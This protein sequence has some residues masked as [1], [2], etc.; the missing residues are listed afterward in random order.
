[1]VSPLH[2]LVPISLSLGGYHVAHILGQKNYLDESRRTESRKWT[3]TWGIFATSISKTWK[4]GQ[5]DRLCYNC[6]GNTM[7]ILWLSTTQ[8]R[9]ERIA[10][11]S[12]SIC[13]DR[14]RRMGRNWKSRKGTHLNSSILPSQDSFHPLDVALWEHH[15]LDFTKYVLKV[16]QSWKHI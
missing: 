8:Q 14:T 10:I 4:S 9:E 13:L 1:M 3:W 6:P 16:G 5:K 12:C 2:P 7:G 15:H 11:H